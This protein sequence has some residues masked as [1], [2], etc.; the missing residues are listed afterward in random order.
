MMNKP[1]LTGL[2]LVFSTV[3]LAQSNAQT[4][5]PYSLFG[6]GRLNDV[7]TGITNSLGKRCGNYRVM[8]ALIT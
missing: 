7:N 6:I 8:V 1:V 5:S 2:F 3:A 4:S